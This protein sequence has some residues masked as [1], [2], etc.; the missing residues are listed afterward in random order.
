MTT[1][2]YFMVEQ[3]YNFDIDDFCTLFTFTAEASNMKKVEEL[4]RGTPENHSG[5]GSRSRSACY[6]FATF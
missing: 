6:F 4:L 2:S 1:P 3:G 5:P